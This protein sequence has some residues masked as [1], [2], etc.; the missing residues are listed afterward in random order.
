M[1]EEKSTIKDYCY[2]FWLV[3]YFLSIFILIVVFTTFTIIN[4]TYS[5]KKVYC[6]V[7]GYNY[8]VNT[9]MNTSRINNEILPIV[10]CTVLNTFTQ[11]NQTLQLKLNWM[12]NESFH[13]QINDTLQCYRNKDE[14]KLSNKIEHSSFIVFVVSFVCLL[15]LTILPCLIVTICFCYQN[16]IKKMIKK[17]KEKYQ[18]CLWPSSHVILNESA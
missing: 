17:L 6:R 16:I 9:E 4:H 1:Q 2:H 18:S 12:R 5:N 10:N 15:G 11:Q 7:S 13:Y 3:I 8:L 14:C